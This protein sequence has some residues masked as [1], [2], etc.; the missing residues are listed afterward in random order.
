MYSRG[1]ASVVCASDEGFN[2]YHAPV[3]LCGRTWRHFGFMCRTERTGL[4][5]ANVS[6][7]GWFVSRKNW[8]SF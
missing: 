2:P 1:G 6:G 8:R 7:H 4:T 5:C 3:L